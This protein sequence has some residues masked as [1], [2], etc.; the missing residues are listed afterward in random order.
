MQLI[1]AFLLGC[2]LQV[3]ATGVS[4]TVTLSMKNARLET[5]LDAVKAQTGYF[6]SY[7]T[8]QLKSARPVTVHADRMP[9]QDFLQQM[10]KD[11][12]LEFAIKVNTIFI[13]KGKAPSPPTRYEG[14]KTIAIPPPVE[15]KGLVTNSKGEPLEGVSV[16]I[17]GTNKGTITGSDGMFQLTVSDDQLP[18]ELEFSYIGY[19]RQV[20]KSGGQT[21]FKIA[22]VE[23][24]DGF[25]DVVVVGYGVQKK[26]DVTGAIS[27]V[28][29]VDIKQNPAANLSNSIAGRIPG[30]IINNRSGE[31]G[32]D[33]S[34]IF[35]R[36]K[37]TLNDNS[38]L[39]VIDGIAN[40]GS[41]D[42]LNP[43]DIES[44]TVLKD[45]SAAIYGAQ[46]ANG[47]I[48]V[49]TKRGKTGDP[50]ITYDGNYSLTQPTRLP[51][52]IN[53]W[54]YATYK[55][56]LNART[57]LPAEFT[58]EQIQHYK[59]GDDLVNYPN[60]NWL[61]A[62]LKD[63]SPQTR[64]S[65]SLRG[66]SEKVSYFVSGG[67][68]YQDGIFRNSA[69]N[70]NQ[71]NL[72]SNLD[73]NIHKNFK[74][75]LDIAGRIEDRRYSNVSGAELFSYTYGTFPTLPDFYPNGLPGAGVEAGR[76]P[77]LLASGASGFRKVKDYFLQS[78]IVFDLKLPSITE[79]LSLS[80]F[81]GYNFQFNN[82]KLL[83]DNWDSYRYDKNTDLYINYRNNLGPIN[84]TESFRNY[85]LAT[86]N[87]KLGYDRSFNQHKV[88][89]FIAY[90]QSEGFDEGIS[91]YR[92]GY[93]TNQIDQI[94]LGGNTGL[95]N[96]G[97]AFQSA[98]QNVFGRITYNFDERYLAEV[99]LRYDGSFNF[100]VG[101]QWGTFPGV[102]LGWRISEESFFKNNVSFINQLKLRASWARL[103]NDKISPYQSQLQY[104]RDAGYYFGANLDRVP[105]LSLG[106]VPNPF[107]TWEVS[108]TKNLGIEASLWGGALNVNADY[109][110]SKRN[111]ILVSRNASIPTS[112]GLS[113]ANLPAENIGKVSSNGFELELFHRG[114]LGGYL[115]YN[116]GLNFTHTQNKID[117]IDEAAGVPDWQ[118]AQGHRMDSWLLYKTD[119]IYRSQAEIDRSAHLA[120]VR[121]GDIKYIDLNGDGKI[122]SND[123]I[124]IYE[125]ATPLNIFGAPMGVRYK[126]IGLN[127]L[128]QGQSKAKQ[129]IRPTF[130]PL[131]LPR[132]MY[133]DRW[134]AAN[135]DGK[136]PASFA[137]NDNFNTLESDFWLRDASFIR[138]KTVELSYNF[139]TQTLSRFNVQ[140][141][142]MYL[143]AFNLFTISKI[144][145]YDPELSVSNGGYYPQTRI[146]NA[147]VRISL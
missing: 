72:R 119:G 89:A 75:S 122:T 142:E 23:S 105:G 113:S 51:E 146:Y 145:D 130:N 109:F 131:T 26:V 135:T 21:M 107:V 95:N 28:K 12:P 42:R 104:N 55:N 101:R 114:K 48:L 83:N 85:K 34:Q 8:N 137:P 1:G 62:I 88:G 82:E 115:T 138:L 99:I 94:S 30:V 127:L 110:F 126:G 4:Q 46:A 71:Y 39:I 133:D 74:I 43:E 64:H 118:K 2:C 111:N 80:G 120:G 70:Y 87:I 112:T 117:F 69:T 41:F 50:L 14:E 36:G 29:G 141:I 91:A 37:G 53:A 54:E 129:V 143:S 96:S 81:A 44:V 38:P 63:L 123:Q 79:G 10:L 66:G 33:A 139:P 31:P 58:E 27:V 57:G 68:L 84:L 67:Y 132:W 116:I 92:T 103:G 128:W 59:D 78:R 9:L 140:N 98:R 144:K 100:P 7:K 6:V 90:E 13:K 22:L 40:A 147:G 47:V 11:Q 24:I 124:R 97:T 121:P 35:I 32:R 15:L 136:M 60:T 18:I 49:T 56:E 102:S 77:V 65:L 93:L 61:N 86:Y 25:A 125:S 106:V 45:A 108:D 17:V 52:L 16:G 20:V 3:A 73:A 76:N 5:V 134:T 19:E